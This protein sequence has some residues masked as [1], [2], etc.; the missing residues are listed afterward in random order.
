MTSHQPRGSPKL[1]DYYFSQNGI[2]VIPI[3]HISADGLSRYFEDVLL[4]RNAFSRAATDLFNQAFKSYWKRTQALYRQSPRYWFPPRVQHVCIVTQSDLIRPYFQPFNRN[5]WLL[6]ASD[7]DPDTSTVE[8]AA[9]QFLHVERMMMLRQI[10]PALYYNLGY[11]LM[12]T[13]HQAEAFAKGCQMTDRPDAGGFQALAGALPWIRQLGHEQL[14]K[15]VLAV[16]GARLMPDTGLILGADSQQSLGELQKTWSA[17]TVEVVNRHRKA[18][19]IP[20]IDRGNKICEWL[21]NTSPS[22]LIKGANN[23]VLWNPEA[24][25]DTG[26]VRSALAEVTELGELSIL[27]D[28]QVVGYHSQRFLDSLRHRDELADPAPYMSAGGLSH[29]DGQWKLIAYDIGPGP[30]AGRVWESTPPYERLMLGARTI[31][32][33]GHL[34]AYSGWVRV[35]EERNNEREEL[36]RR[37]VSLFEVIHQQA[38]ERVRDYVYREVEQL[39][40]QSVSLG[41]ALL[42]AMLVRVEDFMSNL[43]AQRY[44]SPD[45]MDT[46]VRNN[47]CCH[48]EEYR[49][50]AIYMQLVRQAYEFQYLRL[51]RIENPME[52]FMKS[53]WF[54]E[55]FIR[56]GIITDTLFEELVDVVGAICDCYEVDE[57][58]FNFSALT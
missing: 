51:S 49:S 50:G 38:S 4:E 39:S 57:S 53:T 25:S 37:L 23:R 45:E 17:S 24:A 40:T 36:N 16:P 12:L 20:S 58:K 5:S 3:E 1:N 31:H 33:W 56:K 47:V 48:L 2:F 19:A 15:P 29:I 8:F 21:Q 55:H 11:F 6:Y 28:L 7:F 18:H 26:K 46:Y 35:P 13:D 44:L 52:W 27:K 42:N 14:R 22:L 54:G 34:A 43:L 10:N 32:E 30:N 41:Q 9:Y